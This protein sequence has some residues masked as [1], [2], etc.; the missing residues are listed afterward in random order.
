MQFKQDKQEETKI[1]KVHLTQKSNNINKPKLM[2]SPEGWI[3]RQKEQ[4]QEMKERR[5]TKLYSV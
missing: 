3:D 1:T 5:K 2:F 4:Y